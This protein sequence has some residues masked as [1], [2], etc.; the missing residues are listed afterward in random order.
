MSVQAQDRTESVRSRSGRVLVMDDDAEVADVSRDMLESLGYVTEI[1]ASGT[2]AIDQFRAAEQ[3][4]R[5]F[6]MVILDL[7]VPGGM[8]GREAVLH[9]RQIRPDVPVVVTSGYADDSVLAHYAEYGFDGVLPK[10]FGIPDLRRALEQAETTAARTRTTQATAGSGF[11]VP[12]SE[13]NV[14][15]AV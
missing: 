14:L 5:P 12:C 10:P 8:G 6:D 15:G 9:I 1:A 3:I 7:T 11:H 2:D 13:L 4:G